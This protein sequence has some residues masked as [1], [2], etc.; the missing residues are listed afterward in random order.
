MSEIQKILLRNLQI[1]DYLELKEGMI[2]SYSDLKESYW[3]EDHIQTLINKFPDGQIVIVVDDVVVGVALSIIINSADFDDNHKYAEITGNSTFNTHTD[4]GDTLYGIDVFVRPEYRGLRLGRRLY[5]ARKELCE[6]LNLK[7]ILF[8]GR[9]PNYTDYAEELSPRVYIEKV[10]HSEIYDPVLTFQLNNDFHVRKV[11]KGYMPGDKS[12]KEYAALLEW[13]NIYF[14]RSPKLM[15][16][17]KSII[18]LGLV[19][20]QMRPVTGIDM[21]YDQIEFFVDAVSG[22]NCD[23]TLF[24]ELF[25][26][27]LMSEFNH[28]P[29]S[30]AIRELAKYTE[31]I[32]NKLKEL[33]ISYNTNI[34][35]G[36]MPYIE[37][38]HLYNVGFLCRRDGSDE[39]YRKIHITPNEISYWGMVGGNEIK[40]FDTDCGKIGVMICYDVEFPELSR[41]MALEKMQILFVPFL[42]DTQNGFT[43]VKHCAQ[44]RAIENECYVA[45]A[46][47]VGNLPKVNNMDIQYAQSA[48]YTP[49]DFAF[50]PNGI[51]AEATPNNEMTLIVDVDVDLLKE[52]HEYGTI[53]AIKDRRTDLYNLHK[54][55]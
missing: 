34:I 3:Q 21:L 5:D 44:A 52:L 48:V 45:V 54:Q 7:S 22:Y 41:L 27:P 35:G 51:K 16:Q 40:T 17:K 31:P 18:R 32:K 26:A 24:P 36:S 30:E 12:S 53:R 15:N 10:R 9:M 1:D 28:L 20:W 46:G 42:T 50:P 55:K 25:N 23:F 33:A 29:E 13:N 19:Q 38:G 49:S 43:R 39:M 47:S 11:I 6:N 37:D 4:A 14:E 2:Q 8:G